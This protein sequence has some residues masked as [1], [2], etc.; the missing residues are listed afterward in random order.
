MVGHFLLTITPAEEDL[1]LTGKL[2]YVSEA[3]CL[4]QTMANGV[5]H[6]KPGTRHWVETWHHSQGLFR[7]MD[8]GRRAS[9][10]DQRHHVG[11]QYDALV[12]RFGVERVA[13][14]I[15]GR[16]LMNRLRRALRAVKATEA[17]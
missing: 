15:R 2:G 1:I 12:S 3:R 13:T 9:Y 17:V 11:Y 14:A 4:L 6:A 10:D 8:V 5:Q 7:S 16:V